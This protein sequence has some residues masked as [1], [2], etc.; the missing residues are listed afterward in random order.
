MTPAPESGIEARLLVAADNYLA[1]AGLAALLE[2]RGWAV[3]AAVDSAD[4]Q[5]HIDVYEPDLLV[6]DLGWGSADWRERLRDL[7]MDSPILA[8]TA[9]DVEAATAIAL[10]V[11]IAPQFALLQR[12]SDG[13]RI[14]AA[15]EALFAGLSVVD[16]H[17]AGALTGPG[18]AA[19]EPPQ[20]PLTPR[21]NEVLQLLAR[22][23]TNKAIAVELGIT[24]HTVKFH[25]NAIMSKLD[26]QSRTDAVVRATRLGMIIL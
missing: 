24:P 2:E 11:D 9:D 25:V 4:L 14:A 17:L 8:L 21:E 22:G 1:R 19:L 6:I 3:Q 12:E 13:D 7:D 5:R 10:I 20:S 18:R 16:P 15:L 23:L 26:A